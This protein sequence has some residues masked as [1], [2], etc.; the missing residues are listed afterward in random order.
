MF[1]EQIRAAFKQRIDENYQQK[2]AEWRELSP[3]ELIERAEEISATQMLQ[4]QLSDS[5]V[6]ETAAYLLRF[7]DPLQ[8]VCDCW[9]EENGNET[10]HD[11][12]I[13]HAVWSLQ[14][15]G[16]AELNYE[17]ASSFRVEPEM[18]SGAGNVLSPEAEQDLLGKIIGY[19]GEYFDGSQLYD[20]LHNTLEM[21]HAEMEGLGFDL[22]HCYA[23]TTL[24]MGM[25][26]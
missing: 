12:E 25:Q 10:M 7:T 20:I 17:L 22:R 21:S 16:L 24:D 15:S 26:Q 1:N 19:M 4:G 6:D 23:A 11:E 18:V 3:E 5:I 9:I 2:Q 8:A 14:D 13:G